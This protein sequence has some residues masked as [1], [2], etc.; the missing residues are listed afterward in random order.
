MT[1]NIEVVDPVKDRR[2]FKIEKPFNL[3]VKIWNVE[4][5]I[6]PMTEKE[7]SGMETIDLG[8]TEPAGNFGRKVARKTPAGGIRMIV[9]CINYREEGVKLWY[10]GEKLEIAAVPA[11]E[12]NELQL[13][14]DYALKSG[15][16]FRE[17]KIVTYR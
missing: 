16:T 14:F 7:L 3:Y 17:T 2:H 6:E 13:V 8:R 15:G 9:D 5:E 4:I 11:P 10:T 1:Q 12:K